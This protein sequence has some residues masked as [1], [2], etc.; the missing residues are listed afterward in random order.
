MR[1]YLI[2][3]P[4]ISLFL[5]TGYKWQVYN[6]QISSMDSVAINSLYAETNL[7][8][9]RNFDF[10]SVSEE[11][12]Y[13]YIRFFV[14]ENPDDFASTINITLQET[15]PLAINVT[16]SSDL[17]DTNPTTEKTYVLESSE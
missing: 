5:Y 16:V 14:F 4:F 10:S 17:G 9:I 15:N 3:I 13:D 1:W 12:F 2:L 11:F 6:E 8:T 7:A